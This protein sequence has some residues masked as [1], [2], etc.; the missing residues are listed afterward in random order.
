MTLNNTFFYTIKPEDLKKTWNKFSDE[1]NGEFKFKD[2]IRAHI[3]SAIYVYEITAKHGDFDL[4]VN[5]TVYIHPGNNDQPTPLTYCLTRKTNQK[6]T[7]IIWKRD[8]LEKILGINKIN[9]GI[10]KIDNRYSIKTNNTKL[11]K[12]IISDKR[13]IESLASSR[14][15]FHIETKNRTLEIVLKRSGISKST[16]DFFLDIEILNLVIKKIASL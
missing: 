6:I 2:P 5:Q 16:K 8:F 13:L 14:I 12:L 1:I 3:S 11:A 9:S 7:F 4:K 10:D 15:H